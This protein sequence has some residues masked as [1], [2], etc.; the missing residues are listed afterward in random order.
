MSTAIVNEVAKL[1]ASQKHERT[2]PK[3]LMSF[4]H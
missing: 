1:R 2:T 3:E 4:G